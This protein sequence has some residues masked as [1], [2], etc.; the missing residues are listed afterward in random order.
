[1]KKSGSMVMI[2]LMLSMF[3][4][5]V[6][7]AQ[8]NIPQKVEN[9]LSTAA[10]TAEPILRY[11]VGPSTAGGGL[12]AGEMLIIKF[13]ILIVLMSF[14]YY[15]ASRVPAINETPVVL[16]IVTIVMAIL[17]TR[18]L[19]TAAL[20]NLVWLPTGTLGIALMSIF[21]F[22]IYL[23]FIESFDSTIVRKVGWIFFA[24]LFFG[25]SFARWDTLQS[26]NFNLGWIY[27]IT[28]VLSLLMIVFDRQIRKM[29]IK[30]ATRGSEEELARLHRASLIQKQEEIDEKLNRLATTSM[31]KAERTKAEKTLEDQKKALKKRIDSLS[32]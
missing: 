30:A 15:A 22:I 9:A 12:S 18:F 26:G 11:L 4:V 31:T 28:G 25:L 16:W 14:I 13:L 10:Q 20:V 6:V 21:P 29:I 5:S 1:M 32:Y 24:V 17:A 19:T 2:A 27:I 7:S 23:F 3:L 8:S